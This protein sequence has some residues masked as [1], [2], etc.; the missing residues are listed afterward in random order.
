M[1]STSRA[2]V[3]RA[4]FDGDKVKRI[5]VYF[6][7]AYEASSSGSRGSCFV[8]P[9]TRCGTKCRFAEPGPSRLRADGS[10]FCGA[11]S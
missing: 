4:I 3:I 2:D 1:V 7:A 11:S 6:G 5:D 8:F 10:R 9:R